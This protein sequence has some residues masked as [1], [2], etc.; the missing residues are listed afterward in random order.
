VLPVS[1]LLAADGSVAAVLPQPFR[2]VDEIADAVRTHL[3][4]SA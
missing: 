2:S 1:V 4:V 3:G